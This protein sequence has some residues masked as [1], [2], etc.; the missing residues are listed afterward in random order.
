MG[1]LKLPYREKKEMTLIV[2]YHYVIKY[3]DHKKKKSS[4]VRKSFIAAFFI[5]NIEDFQMRRCIQVFKVPRSI[6]IVY[7]VIFSLIRVFM[8]ILPAEQLFKFEFQD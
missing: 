6:N 2:H 7:T 5:E 8:L 4:R 1:A 3:I